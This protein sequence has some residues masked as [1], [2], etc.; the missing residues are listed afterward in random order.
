MNPNIPSTGDIHLHL[1]KEIV[2]SK[3]PISLCPN[4]TPFPNNP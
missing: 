3:T 1:D 4:S 2:P